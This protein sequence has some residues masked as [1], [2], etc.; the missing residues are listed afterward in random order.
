MIVPKGPTPTKSTDGGSS[1]PKGKVMPCRVC[2]TCIDSLL[3]KDGQISDLMSK[4]GKMANEFERDLSDRDTTYE[5]ER[6]SII[7]SHEKFVGA[8]KAA[9]GRA[10]DEQEREMVKTQREIQRQ[11]DAKVLEMTESVNEH[12]ATSEQ[13]LRALRSARDALDTLALSAKRE[14]EEAAS[15]LKSLEAAHVEET[16]HCRAVESAL[17]RSR[18]DYES[19]KNAS[20]SELRNAMSATTAAQSELEAERV[21]S[22]KYRDAADAVKVELKRECESLTKFEANVENERRVA[23]ARFEL[24]HSQRLKSHAI[25]EET[26]EARM[27]KETRLMAERHASEMDG[28]K[29]THANVLEVTRNDALQKYRRDLANA[30][31]EHAAAIERQRIAIT[32]AHRRE[33]ETLSSKHP[34]YFDELETQKREMQRQYDVKLAEACRLQKIDMERVH[35]DALRAC[36]A[37]HKK[38]LEASRRE[39]SQQNAKLRAKREQERVEEKKS[40]HEE[41]S[42]LPSSSAAAKI[43]NA[44]EPNVEKRPEPA[45]NVKEG[46]SKLRQRSRPPPRGHRAEADQACQCN[47]S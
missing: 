18:K 11:S 46:P 6:A 36:R 33:I 32:N 47:I 39:M 38:E 9:H 23:T 20:T 2:D 27:R 29:M 42:S 37:A 26:L 10:L 4:M 7:S 35:L 30:T 41:G 45:S 28:L 8:L 15:S 19:Y 1:S 17:D 21:A 5:R 24:I 25:A 43:E 14:R 34:K 16:E 12:R 40:N 31:K 44:V 3:S 22:K 13:R